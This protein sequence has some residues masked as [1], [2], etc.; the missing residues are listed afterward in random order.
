MKRFKIIGL[1]L[2]FCLTMPLVVSKQ[3]GVSGCGLKN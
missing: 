3:Y 2:A 1:I